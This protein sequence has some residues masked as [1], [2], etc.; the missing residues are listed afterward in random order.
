MITKYKTVRLENNRWGETTEKAKKEII[1]EVGHDKIEW[2]ITQE[3]CLK[4]VCIIYS[5]D[6]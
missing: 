4:L 1:K 3:K 2:N 5:Y 6:E